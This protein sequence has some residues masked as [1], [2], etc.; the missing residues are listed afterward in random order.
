MTLPNPIELLRS[1][2]RNLDFSAV[3]DEF[4]EMDRD[5]LKEFFRKLRSCLGDT[6]EARKEEPASAADGVVAE[7]VV[8]H[9]DGG[10]RGNPGPAGYGFAITDASGKE[11][12]KGMEYLG[13]KTNNVAEYEGVVAGIRAALGM[14]AKRIV[15]K[16]DSQLLVRQLQGRY[17]VRS[18]NLKDLFKKTQELLSRFETW[19]AEHIPR[20]ENSLA[21]ALANEAMDKGA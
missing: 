17:R 13:L 15:V 12:A 1:I 9:S 4:P 2:Y 14:N 11:L 6:P 8:L 18:A 19:R 21:D 3:L 5:E 10:S 16:S 7:E 20:E